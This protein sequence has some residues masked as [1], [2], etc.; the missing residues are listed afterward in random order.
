MNIYA[1]TSLLAAYYCP[2]AGSGKAQ[3]FLAKQEGVS[4]SWLTETE[5]MSAIS[6]KVRERELSKPDARRI[7][8][9]FQEHVQ[10]GY[11]EV[12]ALEATDY[13]L[14]KELLGRFDTPLRALDALHVAVALRVAR[15]LATADDRLAKAA[16]RCSVK[17]HFIR[18]P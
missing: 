2:E 4:I 5:M 13:R 6:R 3:V 8:D 7:A 18:Y 11:Y 14:A 16:K 15:P 1:D 17:S 12:L 10:G 9:L